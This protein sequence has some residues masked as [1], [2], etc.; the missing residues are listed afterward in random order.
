[1]DNSAELS[2]ICFYRRPY[3]HTPYIIYSNNNSVM[4]YE[5]VQK[6]CTKTY[7]L[8]K[9]ILYKAY[10]FFFFCYW[11]VQGIVRYFLCANAFQQK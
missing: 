11:N 10:L 1:M 5:H 6:E 9:I 3:Y 8:N 7:E 2:T 4:Q